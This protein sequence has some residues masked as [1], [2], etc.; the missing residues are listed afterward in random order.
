MSDNIRLDVRY[1]DGRG[2]VDDPHVTITPDIARQIEALARDASEEQQ[3]PPE[4]R[5]APSKRCVEL[6]NAA[7]RARV[8]ELEKELATA[9]DG[10]AVHLKSHNEAVAERDRALDDLAAEREHVCALVATSVEQETRIAV[11]RERREKAEAQAAAACNV[12][13]AGGIAI[14]PKVI[15]ECMKDRDA[16]RAEVERL[17]AISEQRYDCHGKNC[18]ACISCL[19]DEVEMLKARVVKLPPPGND[20]DDDAT[21]TGPYFWAIDVRDAL[22]AAGVDY[23]E[24]E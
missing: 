7:L 4:A 20:D 2:L 6:E 5:I 19:H 15:A 21:A 14:E 18:G 16:A 13:V 12:M 23:H 1:T 8:A 11:E 3:F 10:R 22:D 17:R 24:H 9:V